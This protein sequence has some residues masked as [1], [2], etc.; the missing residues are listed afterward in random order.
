LD[1]SGTAELGKPV[2]LDL[3]EQKITLPLLG[4]LYSANEQESTVVRRKVLEIH[5]HPEY[6]QEIIQFVFRYKGIDYAVKKLEEF[7]GKA[8]KALEAFPD[9]EYKEYL[10]ILANYVGIRER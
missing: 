9:G 3:K 2:G 7:L 8:I 1:Y 4:A 5:E 10:T 6:Q